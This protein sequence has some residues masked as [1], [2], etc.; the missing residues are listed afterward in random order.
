MPVVINE[1]EIVD[2]PPQERRSAKDL[3]QE[4]EQANRVLRIAPHTIVRIIRHQKERLARVR[5]H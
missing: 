2:E 4:N 3:T 5:A 1:F